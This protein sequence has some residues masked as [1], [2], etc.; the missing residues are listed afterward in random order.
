MYS[1]I[2]SIFSKT[3]KPPCYGGQKAD[4]LEKRCQNCMIEDTAADWMSAACMAADYKTAECQ[5]I[6]D[7]IL[8]PRSLRYIN[9]AA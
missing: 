1:A 5:K 4:A 2:Y 9:F 3:C 6:R 7:P 8:Q